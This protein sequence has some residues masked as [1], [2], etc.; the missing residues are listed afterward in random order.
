MLFG[1][2]SNLLQSG[3]NPRSH[4]AMPAATIIYVHST[5]CSQL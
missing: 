4:A 5:T 3:L 2:A 1:L